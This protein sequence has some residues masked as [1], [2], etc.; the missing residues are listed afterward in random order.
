M[1]SLEKVA[2]YP[3]IPQER[4]QVLIW[5]LLSRSKISEMPPEVREVAEK[6]LPR[7]VLPKLDAAAL[8]PIPPEI[9]DQVFER[10]PPLVRKVMEAEGQIRHLLSSGVADFAQI[11]AIAVLSGEPEEDEEKGPEIPRGRWSYAPGGMF[12]RYFPNGYSRTKVQMYVPEP[13]G[14][15][16]DE[17]GRVTWIGDTEGLEI[18]VEHEG[19][20]ALSIRGDRGVRAYAIRRFVLRGPDGEEEI[21]GGWTFVGL[22]GGRGRPGAGEE[23]FVGLDER[24]AQAREHGLQLR[25]LASAVRKLTRVSLPRR[26]V[27]QLLSGMS[28]LANLYWALGEAAGDRAEQVRP[29]MELVR[30]A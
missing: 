4:V 15:A 26:Q 8:V 29:H 11:E 5:G 1:F 13:V 30:R 19:D 24:Y 23:P 25:K 16:E 14:V 3:Q 12:V 22:P 2:A 9:A 6:L 27:A 10:L 21:A 18:E 7:E 28:S 17:L 20:E